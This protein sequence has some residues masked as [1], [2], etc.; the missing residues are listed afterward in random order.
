MLFVDTVSIEMPG[1]LAL[2]PTDLRLIVQ[3]SDKIFKIR[4]KRYILMPK[5]EISTCARRWG[6][7]SLICGEHV[8]TVPVSESVHKTKSGHKTRHC[9]TQPF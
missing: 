6:Q 7:G 3:L 8:V 1:K 9:S 2:R 5:T 4:Q